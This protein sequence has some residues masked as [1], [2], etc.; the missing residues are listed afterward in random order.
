MGPQ[1]LEAYL[2]LHCQDKETGNPPY[3]GD[4]YPTL[5]KSNPFGFLVSVRFRHLGPLPDIISNKDRSGNIDERWVR[6]VARDD[7]PSYIDNYT[8]YGKDL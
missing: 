4:R 8:R 5:G 6:E 7:T 2:E 1:G 3:E